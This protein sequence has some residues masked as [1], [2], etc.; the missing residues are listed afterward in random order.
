MALSVVR[1][2][3]GSDLDLGGAST[4]T[5]AFDATGGDCLV[6]SAQLADGLAGSRTITGVTYNGLALTEVGS[7]NPGTTADVWLG[8][9]LSPTTGTNNVVV[10]ASSALNN[11]HD[12]LAINCTLLLGIN[13]GIPVGSAFTNTGSGVTPTVDVTGSAADEIVVDSVSAGSS[14]SGRGA[15][16][17]G[18]P[19]ANGWT[20]LDT[21]TAGGNI[22]ASYETGASTVTMSWTCTSDTW[23]AVAASFKPATDSTTVLTLV[24]LL[25]PP[26]QRMT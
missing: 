2:G 4:F 20:N 3:G 5:F 6:V 17:T 13:T 7:L 9:R 8:Y 14:F 10:T 23:Q 19:N 12:V 15:G 25:P 11:V 1:T 16:Q 22:A 24:P 18:V 21:A 26:N